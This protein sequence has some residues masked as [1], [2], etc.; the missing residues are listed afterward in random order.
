MWDWITDKWDDILDWIKDTRDRTPI[1]KF[2]T[3]FVIGISSVLVLYALAFIVEFLNCFSCGWISGCFCSDYRPDNAI[4]GWTGFECSCSGYDCGWVYGV[5][6][7][8]SWNIFLN[9]SLFCTI[10]GGIIGGTYGI[11]SHKQEHKNENTAQKRETEK[12]IY[13]STTAVRDVKNKSDTIVFLINDAEKIIVSAKAKKMVEEAAI[14]ANKSTLMLESAVKIAEKVKG[15][16]SKGALKLAQQAE[17]LTR[18]SEK[19]ADDANV[20]YSQAMQEEQ[21]W[22][23]LQEEAIDAVNKA[24]NAANNAAKET[25]KIE[26]TFFASATAKDAVK[27]VAFA[28]AKAKEASEKAVK[29]GEAAARAASAQEAQIE[30]TQ[31]LNSE[32]RAIVEEKI[33]VEEAKIAIEGE[34]N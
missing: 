1:G 27:K 13:K 12:E 19:D 3:I 10:A 29:S 7:I 30:V 11:A 34:G 18:L 23:R 31:A 32:K 9:V 28:S 20:L 25:A 8:W 15:K 6:P 4:W 14:E 21:D 17:D 33:A 16:S 2:F 22:N 26:K 24:K 5:F